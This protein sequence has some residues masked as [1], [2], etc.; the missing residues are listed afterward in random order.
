MLNWILDTKQ[1]QQVDI[2]YLGL[3][4]GYTSNIICMWIQYVG[5]DSVY[6]ASIIRGEQYSG[7]DTQ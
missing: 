3:D 1:N 2:Q 4:S 7:L 6:T 5:L